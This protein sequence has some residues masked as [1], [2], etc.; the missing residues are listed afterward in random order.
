MSLVNHIIDEIKELD[1]I[2]FLTI[3]SYVV[4]NNGE[5][6]GDEVYEKR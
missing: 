1:N 2:E 3:Y 5:R 4:M 6:F